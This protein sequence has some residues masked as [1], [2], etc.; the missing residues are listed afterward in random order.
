[1]ARTFFDRRERNAK[2]GAGGSPCGDA[3]CAETA[4]T[5]DIAAGRAAGQGGED[6]HG[7]EGLGRKDAPKERQ[8]GRCAE[9]ARPAVYDDTDVCALLGL[10]RRVLVKARRKETRG[11]DWDVEGM[12]AGMTAAW[13]A[14]WRR[15][16]DVSRL[17]QI[18]PQSGVVTVEKTSQ[19]LNRGVVLA[20]RVCD[21]KRVVVRVRDSATIHVGEQFDAVREGG[22]LAYAEHLNRERY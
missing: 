11:R 12:Q 1:M 14:K 13:I 19:G 6:S 16:A 7:I 20:K 9:A 2:K 10:R 5:A 4:Q 3:P 17:K 15:D 18:S 22:M 21:G 8:E